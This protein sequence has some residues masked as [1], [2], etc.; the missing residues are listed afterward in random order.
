M[1]LNVSTDYSL[2]VLI[3]LASRDE[4]LATIAEISAAFDI[5]ENHLVKVVHLLGKAG[6]LSNT[7]GRG[8]GIR[9]ALP[10]GEINLGDVIRAVEPAPR[11]AECFDPGTNTCSIARVCRLQRVLEDAV[12]AFHSVLDQYTLADLV[13][14]RSRLARILIAPRGRAD[15]P[16]RAPATRRS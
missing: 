8:G 13:T 16:R 5:S 15:T 12:D 4:D 11:P 7:R 3:Y 2:R 14:N 10:P 9:L 1:R 6:F